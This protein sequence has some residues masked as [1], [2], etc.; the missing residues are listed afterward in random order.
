MHRRRQL[1][2]GLIEV[3]V[4]LL[5]LSFGMLAMAR[6]SAASIT[7]QKSAQLR[8][9]G[10]SLA[11]HYGERARL[12]IYGF[13]LGHYDIVA[14]AAASASPVTLDPDAADEDAAGGMAAA[15]RQAFLTLVAAT[16]PDGGAQVIS[17]PSSQARELDIWL[18][19]RD[20]P[21]DRDDSLDAAARHQ[22]PALMD[23]SVRNGRH[24][25]HFRVGL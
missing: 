18:L 10:V 22:C 20:T 17:R 9:V 25:M 3:L 13:D 23:D 12:N 16:L 24:C 8:L 4:A 1:G 6:L 21:A 5:V 7:H 15:D 14:G 2:A 11:Q 19:W